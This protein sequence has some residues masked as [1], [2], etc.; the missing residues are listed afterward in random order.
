[1]G[2]VR[3]EH[4]YKTYKRGHVEA[5]Q[6]LNLTIK[7]GEFLALLGPSGCGKTSTLRMVVGLEEI[8]GGQVFIGNRRVNNVEP[9]DR[10]VALA[11]ETYALYPPLT[12]RQN[13]SFCLRAKALPPE[14]ID[15]R[16]TEV[17]EM[18]SITDILDRK[19]G[20]IGGGQ[21][22][23]VSLARA[24]VREPDVLLLDE[25]LS[26]LDASQRARM[27]VELKRLHAKLRR[28]TV[29]V[30]HDQLEAVAMAERVAIMNLGVLQQVGTFDEIFYHPI[31]EFVAAF[32]GEPPMNMLPCAPKSEGGELFLE[33]DDGSFRLKLTP[34]LRAVVLTTSPRKTKLGVRPIHFEARVSPQGDGRLELPGTVFTYESLGE[35]GQLAVRIGESIILAVIPPDVRFSENQAVW[36]QARSDR[37]HLFDAETGLAI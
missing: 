34:E 16:V 30:T 5:V 15:R 28:T 37:T 12:I 19:P 23:R 21:K 25:P 1:M 27:R 31:N 9:K 24:L 3:L 29:L 10:N 8:T 11:F 13:I 32:V 33:A 18:L 7:D 4:V 36:L 6:D 26:H 2:E 14:E 17:A 20:E 22:Q 35:Q